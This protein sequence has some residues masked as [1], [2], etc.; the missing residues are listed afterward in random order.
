MD[1]NNNNQIQIANQNENG[2]EKK[3]LEKKVTKNL[4]KDY[5][6]LLNG[7]SFKDFSIFVEN[8]SNP[9]EIKVHKS[10]LSSRSPFFNESL[11]QES[12]SI[13]LN[14]FNK[15][16]M[17]SILSYIYYGNISFE[18]Q[19]NLIQLLEISIYFK[20]DLLKEIIQKKILNSI[21]YSN[22]FQFLFQNRNLNLNEIE[23]KC[24]ELINQ[25]F[26]Q[27]QNNENL[28]NLT[29]EE[30]I[31]FI[32]F[33]QEKK[34]IFQFDFFQFLNNWIEKRVNS[35]RLRK[36]KHKM[37]AKKRLFHSFFSLFDKDSISKQDFDK[38]KQFE[39]FLPNS[40]LIHFER[41]IFQIQDQENQTKIKEKEKKI[42]E[43][44]DRI[45][46][47][48]K[49]I[50]L[51]ESENHATKKE[52]R[53]LKSENEK[54]KK[55]ILH[56]KSENTKKEE[57]IASLKSQKEIDE[58]QKP[59]ETRD[60]QTK[61]IK[62]EQSKEIKDEQP[63]ETETKDK[64]TKETEIKS[65][66]IK[67][68]QTKETK[69]EQ[70]KE[71]K[72]EQPKE[73]KDEQPK[74]IKDKQPKE[75]KDEQ[76]KETRDYQPK[77]TDIK[78]KETKDEKPK[79]LE[80]KTSPNENIPSYSLPF[81]IQQI[82]TKFRGYDVL[83]TYWEQNIKFKS[84]HLK[85]LNQKIYERMQ[86]KYMHKNLKVGVTYTAKI[87]TINNH[88]KRLEKVPNS[89]RIVLSKLIPNHRTISTVGNRAY[90]RKPF[91]IPLEKSHVFTKEK[92]Q[93]S[94]R[95]QSFLLENNLDVEIQGEYTPGQFKCEIDGK[96]LN[97]KT[98]EVTEFVRV[99]GGYLRFEDYVEKHLKPNLKF[100]KTKG[101]GGFLSGGENKTETKDEQTKETK[102]EQPKETEIK[103]KETK[104]KDK[105]TKDKQ[106]KE[107]KDEQ[108]KDELKKDE[109]PKEEIKKDEKP[110]DEIKKDDL[111]KDE[112]NKD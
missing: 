81:K 68:K 39:I 28:F 58:K 45:Q 33:K 42:K 101:V 41:A 112:L 61:E 31:K 83:L 25:N 94:Q 104:T 71:I 57:E 56:L 3:N 69:D 92:Y 96:S 19:E 52:N 78:P 93:T 67:D 95:M 79:N 63:K 88:I 102:D 84:I 18:N 1:N 43:N 105:Q 7:N 32:Q 60:Y 51:I 106:P 15:K 46:R 30:I 87:R 37:N 59:K 14:Q 9:F 13:S 72:D 23:I 77:E 89:K 97:F 107:I 70:P 76:S 21:N 65:K 82:Q 26:S 47:R 62:D 20:L 74:E 100:V 34:E 85:L 64:Q 35:L 75:T 5:S 38:L 36:Y 90:L 55:E 109:K 2:N 10:I 11:R 66:E 49:R 73:I 24:F 17:E 54:K 22:F 103:S 29:K 16:E 27:I 110:K 98:V 48:D 12:L 91:D 44:E 4:I 40:F 6:N 8:K 99:G 108:P 50:R 111:K 53:D 80:Q 86:N